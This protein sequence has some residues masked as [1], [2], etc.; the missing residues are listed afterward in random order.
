M[1]IGVNQKKYMKNYELHFCKNEP[2]IVEETWSLKKAKRMGDEIITALGE[3]KEDDYCLI[4]I[5]ERTI[6]KYFRNL[7][8]KLFYSRTIHDYQIHEYSKKQNKWVKKP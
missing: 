1:G 3:D 5:H 7:F 6:W 8:S 4:Q 2:S